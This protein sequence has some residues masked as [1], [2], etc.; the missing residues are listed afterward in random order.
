MTNRLLLTGAAGFVGS[1]VLRHF[2]V[3]TDWD[4]VCPVSFEHKGVSERLVTALEGQDK[5]RVTVVYT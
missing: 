2:L 3:N 4:I 1:H 5:D